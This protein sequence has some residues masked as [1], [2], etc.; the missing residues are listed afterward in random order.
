[1]NVNG[2]SVPFYDPDSHERFRWE[3]TE[4]DNNAFQ[5]DEASGNISTTGSSSLDYEYR[6]NYEITVKVTD[7]GELF[8]SQIVQ[9]SITDVNEAPTLSYSK[10]YVE[11]T[12]SL[13]TMLTP[14]PT[15]YDVDSD[16]FLYILRT[17]STPFGVDSGTGYLY[18]S[19][20][21]VLDY[22]SSITS[23]NLTVEVFDNGIAGSVCEGGWCLST[24][25]EVVVVVTD[26][27]EAPSVVANA[28]NVSEA[29]TAGSVIGVIDASD[30]DDGNTLSFELSVEDDDDAVALFKFEDSLSDD[31][32]VKS[33][34][35]YEAHPSPY[36]MR[37]TATDQDGKSSHATVVITLVDANDRPVIATEQW[38]TIAENDDS[39]TVRVNA[40]D[41]DCCGELTADSAL[42]GKLNFTLLG[43]SL[44]SIESKEGTTHAELSPKRE[45]DYEVTPSY[46]LDVKVTDGGGYEA[47]GEVHI[48]VAD[49]NDEPEFTSDCPM[50]VAVDSAAKTGT[51]VHTV[52][53][54]VASFPSLVDH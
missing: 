13:N 9:I 21:G 14:G 37:A 1:M 2:S 52:S 3:I 25:A 35:N 16:G 46:T 51:V 40:S 33:A 49:A 15:I 8:A 17:N 32:V 28:F 27:N 43:S 7:K 30:P 41:E 48:S 11:E 38:V 12:A 53:L 20:T 42:W 6:S 45:L 24:T 36:I 31:V 5:I 18:V 39:I 23:Y 10:S 44:F 47:S 34:L 29:T 54:V 26:M 50:V 22:E 19:E 4:N